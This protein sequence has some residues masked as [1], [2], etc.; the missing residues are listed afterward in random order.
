MHSLP[1]PS[2]HVKGI[3]ERNFLVWVSGTGKGAINIFFFFLTKKHSSLLHLFPPFTSNLRGKL[4]LTST[5]TGLLGQCAFTADP[6]N[7]FTSL[8]SPSPSPLFAVKTPASLMQLS[9]RT[10]MAT[11]TPLLTVRVSVSMRVFPSS[12]LESQIIETMLTS[13]RKA[14]LSLPT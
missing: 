7:T 1:Q 8:P 12:R 10:H 9:E 11:L 3:N 13:K 2:L 5:E 14:L 6:T 4:L